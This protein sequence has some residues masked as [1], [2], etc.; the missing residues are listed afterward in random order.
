MHIS[1]EMVLRQLWKEG[2][3]LEQNLEEDVLCC[4]REAR[5]D[6]R[7]QESPSAPQLLQGQVIYQS[8]INMFEHIVGA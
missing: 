1:Q 3:P 8:F 4:P 6:T 2:V 5:Q 7:A